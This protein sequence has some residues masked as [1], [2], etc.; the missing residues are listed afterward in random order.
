MR[1]VCLETRTWWRFEFSLTVTAS[2]RASNARSRGDR[3]QSVTIKLFELL[4]MLV[5]ARVMYFWRGDRPRED[6]NPILLRG[7]NSSAVAWVNK[8]SRSRDQQACAL[9][10]LLGRIEVA[11]SWNC[12]ATHVA[13]TSNDLADGVSRWHRD[14]IGDRVAQDTGGTPWVEFEIGRNWNEPCCTVSSEDKW[15][16]ETEDHLQSLIGEE[17]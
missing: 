11:R 17:A 3:R 5:S 4:G 12:L 9:M 2:F 7:G 6:G 14:Q 16:D 1:G 15:D 10:T 13:G 8:R